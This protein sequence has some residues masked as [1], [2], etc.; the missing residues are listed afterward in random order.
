MTVVTTE[1]LDIAINNIFNRR[2]SLNIHLY[3]IKILGVPSQ[4]RGGWGGEGGE[5]LSVYSGAINMTNT[6]NRLIV[7]PSESDMTVTI[8]I[9]THSLVNTVFYLTYSLVYNP[10]AS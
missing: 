2:H 6:I 3:R 4:A 8:S 9:R 7:Y 10:T 5:G 1:G